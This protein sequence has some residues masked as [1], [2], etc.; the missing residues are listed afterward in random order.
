MLYAFKILIMYLSKTY[1]VMYTVLICFSL[2]NNAKCVSSVC[3]YD[4]VGY[5]HDEHIPPIACSH[6][7]DEG[8]L[9]TPCVRLN[10]V[11]VF[12]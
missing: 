8:G 1:S 9:N 12:L 11:P 7:S 5:K 2:K 4:D 3:M 10:D 6:P